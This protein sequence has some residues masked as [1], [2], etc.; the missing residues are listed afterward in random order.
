MY[1]RLKR[2]RTE[3]KLTQEE[4][5]RK[6][7]IGKTSISKLESGEN[8]PSEQTIKLICSE[9][10]VNEHW[11]RTGEGSP[12]RQLSPT[13]EVEALVR[14]I[15]NYSS[16]D[17]KNPF[18]D[19]IIDMMKTYHELDPDSQVVIQNYFNKLRLA[20]NSKEPDIVESEID[21]KVSE[22]RQELELEAR[23]GIGLSV[24]E[25]IADADKK[26]A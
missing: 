25:N 1:L 9:F 22:Y 14:K 26:Q 16:Q 13:E 7:G 8:N 4:F 10:N 17:E 19:T 18:Y 23:Q 2:I 6:I 11:L 21:R 3:N 12:T 20:V 24:Y 5:G 15:I